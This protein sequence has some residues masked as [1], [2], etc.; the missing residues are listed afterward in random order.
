MN[1]FKSFEHYFLVLFKKWV[2][3]I[4]IESV[5]ADLP[6][7]NFPK[8]EYYHL[9]NRF[10]FEEKLAFRFQKG[11]S[12][13]LTIWGYFSV[14]MSSFSKTP[15]YLVVSYKEEIILQSKYP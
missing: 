12:E 14:M 13:M 8:L 6:Y 1:I 3:F 5:W 15:W 2:S 11:K 4:P 10:V 7:A 9:K